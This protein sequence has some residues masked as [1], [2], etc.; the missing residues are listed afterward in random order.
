MFIGNPGAFTFTVTTRA[1]QNNQR[2]ETRRDISARE[3]EL[4]LAQRDPA[5]VPVIKN[6]RCIVW[7]SQCF[8]IGISFI[9]SLIHFFYSK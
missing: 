1:V 2:V 5:T 9:H 8:Q 3:Y 6:R 4:L 7:E